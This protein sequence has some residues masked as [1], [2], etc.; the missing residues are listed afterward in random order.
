MAVATAAPRSTI[1]TVL[2]PDHASDH[3]SACTRGGGLAALN[4]VFVRFRLGLFTGGLAASN[5][6]ARDVN[7]EDELEDGTSQL[8]VGPAWGLPARVNSD[9]MVSGRA[10]EATMCWRPVG[11]GSCRLSAQ[12]AEA[13]ASAGA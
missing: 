7:A 5:N 11:R 12:R 3:H 10:R 13:K 1:K 2:H 4:K 8:G 9:I 6:S